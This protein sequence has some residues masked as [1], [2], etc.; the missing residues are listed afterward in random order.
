M[1]THTCFYEGNV[2][3]RRTAVRAHSF[4]YRLFLVYLDLSEVGTLLSRPGLFSSHLLSIGTYR[5]SNYL[6]D[7]E[8]PLDDCVR[9][10][11]KEK[12]GRTVT[13]PV[14]LLTSFRYFGFSMNPVSFY[15]CFDED[16]TT[17]EALVAEVS[18]TPWNERHCY[19]VDA[20]RSTSDIDR[21]AETGDER[22]EQTGS[23]PAVPVHSAVH[24]K[25]FHVSPFF[26]MEMDY[27]WR[28]SD[29]GTALKVQI[30]SVR[31]NDLLFSANLLL[32]RQ[33]FSALHRLRLLVFYPLMTVQIFAGIYW[34]ALRLWVKHVP[35]VPH[36]KRL[37]PS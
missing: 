34:Q 6:G 26:D 29:P 14:R 37:K 27:R 35:Y 15:Y 23:D 2:W 7:P 31:G 16:G 18:N 22:C 30:E 10:L 36:P 32:T 17:L 13:G 20:R 24:R 33:P 4:R 21:I 12:L 9:T 25:E 19:V 1:S 8:R 28:F 5:R 3:H 11:I